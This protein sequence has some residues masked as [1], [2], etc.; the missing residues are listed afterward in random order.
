MSITILT[1]ALLAAFS[2]VIPNAG[3][4]VFGAAELAVRVGDEYVVRAEV[5][6]QVVAVDADGEV[7]ETAMPEP[8]YRYTY[9]YDRTLVAF[10]RVDSGE[11]EVREVEGTPWNDAVIVTDAPLSTATFRALRVTEPVGV[12]VRNATAAGEPIDVANDDR[13][14]I[15]PRAAVMRVRI[16]ILEITPG[17]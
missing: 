11:A 15:V 14:A 7:L 2:I 9:R 16:E 4:T 6:P 8:P 13:I 12:P 3:Y 10:M 5:E 17:E 1:R